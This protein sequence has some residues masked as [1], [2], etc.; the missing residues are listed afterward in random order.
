MWEPEVFPRELQN[1]LRQEGTLHLATQAGLWIPQYRQACSTKSP[2]P[3]SYPSSPAPAPTGSSKLSAATPE[4]S[5][6]AAA[7]VRALDAERGDGEEEEAGGV[8][9]FCGARS[10]S[11]E[12]ASG[13]GGGGA[14]QDD[15]AVAATGGSGADRGGGWDSSGKSG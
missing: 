9:T 6:S 10:G 5:P 8:G 15:D 4:V 3:L 1:H 13:G 7:D 2:L 11:G 14:G 12:A